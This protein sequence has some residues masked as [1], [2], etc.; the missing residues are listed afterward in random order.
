MDSRIVFGSA[1]ER[2]RGRIKRA[3]E[4]TDE[5]RKKRAE[6]FLN[7]ASAEKLVEYVEDEI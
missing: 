2:K 5:E 3:D 6:A 1:K 4:Y 7:G